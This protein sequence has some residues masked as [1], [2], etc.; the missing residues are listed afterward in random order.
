MMDKHTRTASV[1]EPPVQAQGMLSQGK[2]P[3]GRLLAFP[4]PFPAVPTLLA[5]RIQLELLLSEPLIDL[6]DISAAVLSDPGAT[7]QVLRLVGMEYGAENGA[8]MSRPIRME[9]CLASLDARVWFEAICA[10]TL[11]ADRDA[12]ANA[13]SPA[14]AEL[15]AAWEHAREVAQ[16]AMELAERMDGYAPEEACLVGLLHELE[17]LP[18]LLGWDRRLFPGLRSAEQMARAWSLPRP[19]ILCSEKPSESDR[20]WAVLLNEAHRRLDRRDKVA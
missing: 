18:E 6:R 20:Y 12:R 9:D 2:L 5:T 13:E 14:P 4:V 7:L 8:A 19:L 3:K 11:E 15:C 10:A 16:C 1:G 17:D